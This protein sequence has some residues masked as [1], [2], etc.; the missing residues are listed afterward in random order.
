M[1]QITKDIIRGLDEMID[2]GDFDEL[3]EKRFGVRS[4]QVGALIEWLLENYVILAKDKTK[5]SESGFQPLSKDE[6]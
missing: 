4:R 2:S 3:H 6:K 5:V 1:N